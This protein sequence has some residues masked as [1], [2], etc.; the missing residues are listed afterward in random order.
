MVETTQAL[1]A[2]G[3]KPHEAKAAV[4][5]TRT[6]VGTAHLTLEQWIKLALSKCPK[7]G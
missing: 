2:L 7:P 3:W 1:G 6:H 4:E 5:A